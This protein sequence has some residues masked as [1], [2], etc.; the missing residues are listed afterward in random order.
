MHTI[1]TG[2][3]HGVHFFR[4]ICIQPPT[5]RV[6]RS[7]STEQ[8]VIAA[9]TRMSPGTRAPLDVTPYIERIE[10]HP[11]AQTYRLPHPRAVRA[12]PGAGEVDGLVILDAS[13]SWTPRH[14][15]RLVARVR[16]RRARRDRRGHAL[17]GRG[18]RCHRAAARVGQMVP[19]VP[20][21]PCRQA[22]LAVLTLT[23][24]GDHAPRLI[25]IPKTPTPSGVGQISV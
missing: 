4:I 15:G 23:R 11:S 14:P 10:R 18:F 9:I 24:S 1:L 5:R 20:E 12:R 19:G 17:S 7:R 3:K 21:L 25:A 2:L 16:S 22:A 8:S 13:S 6:I